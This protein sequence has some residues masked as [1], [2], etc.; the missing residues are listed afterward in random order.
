MSS[1]TNPLYEIVKSV[2]E[3]AYEQ[4]VVDVT[5]GETHTAEQAF[6]V[7]ASAKET[8][9]ADICSAADVSI[10]DLRAQIQGLL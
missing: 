6:K 2:W 8:S 5:E 1:S 4:A 10:R 3:D 7:S 9:I